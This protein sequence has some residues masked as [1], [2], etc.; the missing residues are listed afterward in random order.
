MAEGSGV[1]AA[2]CEAT[3]GYE[4]PVVGRRREA[5]LSAHLVHPNKVRA[6]ARACGREAKTGGLDAQALSRFGQVFALADAPAEASQE[7]PDPERAELQDLLR[8]RDQLVNQRVQELNRLDQGLTEAA[9]ASTRRHIAWLD[10]EIARLDQERQAALESSHK[11]SRQVELYRSV[12]GVGPLIA[13]TWRR[14]CRNWAGETA[15]G[16]APWRAWLPGPA[17]AGGNGAAGPSGADGGRCAGPCTW[18]PFR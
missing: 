8:R 6:F 17:T 2:V 18:R 15:R 4:R 11:L 9:R 1:S 12:P 13:A 3:G 16:C 5:G 14:T 7:A 10:E